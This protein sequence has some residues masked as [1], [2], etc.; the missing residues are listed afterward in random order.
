MA[1]LELNKVKK[2]VRTQLLVYREEISHPDLC[3]GLISYIVELDN[4]SETVK[5]IKELVSEGF[6]IKEGRFPSVKYKLNKS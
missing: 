5:V 2:I 4:M 6:L 1:K 3:C